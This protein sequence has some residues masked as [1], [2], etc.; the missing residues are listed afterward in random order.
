MGFLEKNTNEV[1]LILTPYGKTKFL[2][3]G[4][5][6]TFRYFSFSDDDIIYHLCVEPQG[7]LEITGSHKSS[8]T[9]KEPRYIVKA[10]K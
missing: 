5:K 3:K 9:Q 7:V 1:K 10:K 6:D 4:F 8:T 2:T